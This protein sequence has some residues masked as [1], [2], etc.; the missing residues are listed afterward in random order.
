MVSHANYKR[1]TE[2]KDPDNIRRALQAIASGMVLKAAA[3]D[4]GLNPRT[5]RRHRDKNQSIF[6]SLSTES[7][8]QAPATTASTSATITS[9]SIPMTI[10]TKKTAPPP[11]SSFTV[12]QVGS[13]KVG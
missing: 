6:A 8:Q 9:A 10:A 4:F 1:K 5:L 3:R 13:P 11:L 12:S 7:E 2:K